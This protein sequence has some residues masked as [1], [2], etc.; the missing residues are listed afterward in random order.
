MRELR[1]FAE[2]EMRPARSRSQGTTRIVDGG[3]D[4]EKSGQ[5]PWGIEKGVLCA[6]LMRSAPSSDWWIHKISL[7]EP[8]S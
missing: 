1:V 8:R 3:T 2:Y 7:K 6:S 4:A 5:R